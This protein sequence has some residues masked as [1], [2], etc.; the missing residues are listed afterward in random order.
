MIQ[1]N[2]IKSK[3]NQIKKKNVKKSHP[4]L[5]DSLFRLVH[6]NQFRECRL[7][8]KKKKDVIYMRRLDREE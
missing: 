4:N 3:P 2:K 8:Q 5:Y 1:I 6:T 7:E